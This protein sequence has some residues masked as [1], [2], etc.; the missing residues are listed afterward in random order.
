MACP[1][2]R[3]KIK[4]TRAALASQGDEHE[5]MLGTAGQS[6]TFDGDAPVEVRPWQGAGR[7]WEMGTAALTRVRAGGLCGL[8]GGR[9][10][11][12]AAGG[13][14]SGGGA[15]VAVVARVTARPAR[16]WTHSLTLPSGSGGRATLPVTL[17]AP[18]TLVTATS[19]ATLLGVPIVT[20]PQSRSPYLALRQWRLSH[21]PSHPTWPSDMSDTAMVSITLLGASTVVAQP[22][23]FRRLPQQWAG[24]LQVVAP[25]AAVAEHKPAWAA[26]AG[27]HLILLPH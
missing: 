6:F 19:P 20:Q 1:L 3:D 14:H 5:L 21:I 11:A 27:A 23:S 9:G 8:L 7:G 22:Y 18:R 25:L 26:T 2:R 4:D 16:E 10:R 13:L 15:P 24:A 17:R 12:G